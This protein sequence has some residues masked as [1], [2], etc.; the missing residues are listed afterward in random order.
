M[1]LYFGVI[2][3]MRYHTNILLYI[4][5]LSFFVCRS[6]CTHLLHLP[7]LI[8]FLFFTVSVLLYLDLCSSCTG[9]LDWHG[10]TL[11]TCYFTAADTSAL[12]TFNIKI[13]NNDNSVNF[14]VLRT[15]ANTDW[16][17]DQCCRN[18]Q[19]TLVS[20]CRVVS[21]V[22]LKFESKMWKVGFKT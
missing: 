8:N 6:F 5:S 13:T 7:H 19:S 17:N 3:I 20:V 15:Q 2:C 11:W 4:L 9:R 1:F 22:C 18:R 16:I 10:D 12:V 21:F 14:D